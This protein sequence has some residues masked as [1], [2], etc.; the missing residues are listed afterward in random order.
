METH[1]GTQK[2]YFKA[3]KNVIKT[4]ILVLFMKRKHRWWWNGYV[5]YA[6][7]GQVSTQ[8]LQNEK[9]NEYINNSVLLAFSALS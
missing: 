9:R 8:I 5:G 4:C 7:P 6:L 1:A 3:T 2:Q